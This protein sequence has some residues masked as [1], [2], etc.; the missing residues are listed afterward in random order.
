MEMDCK[1]CQLAVKPVTA[2]HAGLLCFR[3]INGKAVSLY[4]TRG[5]AIYF[6][7]KHDYVKSWNGSVS[8]KSE[9]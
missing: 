2:M 8:S 4:I 7:L 6:H 5:R 9:A 1:F 3:E